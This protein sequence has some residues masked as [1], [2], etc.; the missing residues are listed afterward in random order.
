MGAGVAVGA[1]TLAS[2]ARDLVSAGVRTWARTRARTRGRA[3]EGVGV[4]AWVW[5]RASV[6]AR[7]DLSMDLGVVACAVASPGGGLGCAPVARCTRRRRCCPC[8]LPEATSFARTP[9]SGRRAASMVGL[10]GGRLGTD[11]EKPPALRASEEGWVLYHRRRRAHALRCR[12]GAQLTLAWERACAVVH[13]WWGVPPATPRALPALWKGPRRWRTVQALATDCVVGDPR[14]QELESPG[15][16]GRSRLGWGRNPQA[17][18]RPRRM[19]S[20]SG[21]F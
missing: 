12:N 3:C 13:S 4:G 14:I 15:G 5:A 1:G 17:R 16:S 18:P 2:P 9:C 7:A 6:W 8:F 11:G 19:W 10:G 21:G 20:E